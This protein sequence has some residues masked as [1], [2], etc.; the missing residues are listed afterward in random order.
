MRM[1]EIAVRD[2]IQGP[3]SPPRERAL[4]EFPPVVEPRLRDMPPYA[5]PRIEGGFEVVR[6]EPLDGQEWDALARRALEIAAADDRV[7]ERLA[8]RRFAAL[9]ASVRSDEKDTGRTVPVLVL[10][11]D[12][13]SNVTVEVELAAEA[14]ELTVVRVEDADY[15]PAPSD[16]EIER[17]IALAREDARVA[18]RITDDLTPRT[19]LVSAVEQGDR[20]HG[21]RRLEVAFGRPTERLPRLRTLVDLG[22]DKVL[23]VGIDIGHETE[24]AEGFADTVRAEEDEQ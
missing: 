21:T 17:A 24:G 7:R 15:Q 12:Y 4:H 5:G 13:D 22:A 23:G 20:H 9:G 10:F 11:Y 19:I 2:R 8:D 1:E 16:D 3:P 6:S 14:E 18:A